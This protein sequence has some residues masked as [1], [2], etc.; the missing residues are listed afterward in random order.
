LGCLATLR[1]TRSKSGLGSSAPTSRAMS[2]NRF[3]CAGSS[4]GGLGLRAMSQL[5]VRSAAVGVI[6][7]D[8]RR[9]PSWCRDRVTATD[10]IWINE[11]GR[12]AWPRHGVPAAEWIRVDEGR[13]LS[14]RCNG[15]AAIVWVLRSLGV[16]AG[17]QEHRYGSQC[18]SQLVH[19]TYPLES[20]AVAAQPQFAGG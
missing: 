7:V 1:K 8:K 17:T 11:S 12:L 9:R 13:G 10:R 3:D 14:R 5:G 20:T 16:C 15:V 4:G 6:R 19:L 18:T 2:I